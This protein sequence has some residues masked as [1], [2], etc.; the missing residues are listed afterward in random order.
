M[1]CF[2]RWD[3]WAARRALGGLD[4]RQWTQRRS[5]P[6]T[7]GA[8]LI[9][10]APGPPAGTLKRP[11]RKGNRP[12]AQ[13]HAWRIGLASNAGARFRFRCRLIEC[14]QARTL[15][16]LCLSVAFLNGFLTLRIIGAILCRA[17]LR[18]ETSGGAAV[19]ACRAVGFHVHSSRAIAFG[20]ARG[21]G[22]AQVHIWSPWRMGTNGLLPLRPIVPGDDR[23]AGV[24]SLAPGLLVSP[25]AAAVWRLAASDRCSGDQRRSPRAKGSAAWRRATFQTTATLGVFLVVQGDR[26]GPLLHGRQGV[27]R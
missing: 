21:S 10:P 1:S 24:G 5:G 12:R 23:V 13:R 17:V 7:G 11:C 22:G 15:R 14:G 19:G 26:F 18:L 3:R 27:R 6:A 8:S 20:R 2:S 16:H 9:A 4:R 25:A